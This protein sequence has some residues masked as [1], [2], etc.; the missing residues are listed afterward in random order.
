MAQE[1]H[2]WKLEQQAVDVV[3][4]GEYAKALEL[5]RE[6]YGAYPDNITSHTVIAFSLINLGR[7]KEA[8]PYIGTQL[9]I[10][11]TGL[12]G[13]LTT[14]YYYAI[15]GDVK[16]AKAY[17]AESIK[18][19][20]PNQSLQE[21]V[22]EMR[23]VG[24]NVNKT[25][26]FDELA[27]WYAQVFPTVNERYPTLGQSLADYRALTGV[28]EFPKVA[29]DYATRFYQ[30]QW[31]ELALTVYGYGAAILRDSGYP[32][33]GLDLA[34]AGYNLLIKNGYGRN[35]LQAAYLLD[36]LIHCYITL[37][38]DER[39]VEYLDE[40]LA[41]SEHLPI[42]VADVNALSRG[43]FC[44]ERLGNNDK[45]REMARA[46]YKL[47]ESAVNRSGAVSAANALCG[48]YVNI[49]FAND[50][51]DAVYYGEQALQLALKYKFENQTGAIIGNLALG[52]WKL[53]TQEGQEKCIRLHGSLV[54]LYKDKKDFA[55]AS[56][57]LNNA[58]S[59]AYAAGDFKWASEL[60]EESVKLS[61]ESIGDLSDNDKL[62]MYQSRISAYEFLVLCYAKLKDAPRT[63]RVMEAS[64]SRV[65]TERL[66]E[67]KRIKAATLDNL[68]NMLA[69]DQAAI[70]YALTSA[71]EVS[72]LV[73]TKKKATVTFHEDESF[74]GDIKEKYLDRMNKEHRERK[75][76]NIDERV[77]SGV[78]VA[79][80]DFQ[81]V[82][83]LTRKFFE[84]PGLADEILNE[85]LRGYH[86]FLIQPVANQLT[87][88]KHLLISPD[89]VLNFVPFEALM[90]PDGKYLVENYGVSYITSTG[91][92]KRITERQYNSS[93][94]SL[95]AMGGAVYQ[96]LAV[97]RAD[98]QTQHDINVLRAEVEENE[99]NHKSQ[100]RAYAAIF[101]TNAFGSLPGA[102]EEVKSIGKYVGGTTIF[103][104]GEMTENKIKAMSQS[105]ELSRYKV[106]HLATHGFV[107]SEFPE[108]S[109]IAMS[110]FSR[111]QNDEDGYLTVNEI[112]DLNLNADLT[113]LSAC[114]TALGKIY[115][116]EGV[117]G[118]TQSLLLAGSNA[119][120]VSLWPVND[121][122]T[123]LFMNGLYEE[124]ARGKS[125]SSV[126]NDLK[127]RFI[128]GEFGAQFA[129]PK[130]WAPFVYVGK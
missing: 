120:L 100:R 43:S 84:S 65:L 90:T 51:K 93:R 130:Y 94:R 35:P 64:R 28:N 80:A 21:I 3:N 16:N 26:T 13:Y 37:G 50:A 32:S 27:M 68:Q 113:V 71:H 75:G 82:T 33:E 111:E 129:H 63:F 8:E 104:G 79:M 48:A 18:V 55:N 57:T 19:F 119:A 103:T 59:F 56:L 46:A 42:H 60:F 9:A 25:A 23:K 110:I 99:L 45:A 123:M 67:G 4:K 97:T 92:L 12:Y 105:G 83:Q 87:G 116:G 77:Q 70:L 126:V 106:V 11:P 74:I 6:L 76:A 112:S 115:S 39:A 86:R 66:S 62:T 47:A 1:D 54:Q 2:Y 10:D 109:G 49:R 30:L 107:V 15:D 5:G 98:L 72:I 117:T 125:Y 88:I 61:E 69:P 122:S 78:R 95:L 127:R 128:K 81:K 85:Y 102:L 52:Y 38:N 96:P 34:Q 58:G 24:S 20:P 14:A 124:A 17:L 114:Q 108:L 101:G 121:T 89:G 44:Y 31:P 22:D 91:A 7:Y 73:V 118:L 41:L 40:V 36:Q 29:A 53:K